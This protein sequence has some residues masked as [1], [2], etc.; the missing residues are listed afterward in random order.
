[1]NMNQKPNLPADIKP[2][3]KNKSGAQASPDAKPDAAAKKA[4]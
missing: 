4:H 1:M 3:E 2:D